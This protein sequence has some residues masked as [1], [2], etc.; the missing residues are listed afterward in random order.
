MIEQSIAA[1][2]PDLIQIDP[3]EGP[4]RRPLAS[5]VDF[6]CLI[7]AEAASQ[8]AGI[9]ALD[10]VQERLVACHLNPALLARSDACRLL[11]AAEQNALGFGI[12]Q[13]R[14]SVQPQAQGFMASRGYAADGSDS[15]GPGPV[16][17]VKSLEA[18]APDWVKRVFA[19]HRQ[20]GIPDNYGARRRLRMVD[21]CKQLDSIGLDVFHRQ[22]FLHPDAA[23]AWRNMRETA[24]QAGVDLQLV[25]AFRAR[26]YQAGLIQAKLERG[27]SME[28][29]LSA[30]AAPGFSEH[31]SGRAVD[32]KAPGSAPLEEDF[33]KTSAYRWLKANAGFFGFFETLGAANVHG[34]IWEP[35][36]WCYRSGLGQ[37]GSP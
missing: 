11:D 3:A 7:I 23:Q 26:E 21:D 18:G 19:L 5:L 9:V 24:A 15:L 29:I 12:R 13:L 4:V 35:W 1:R 8:P 17:L 32:I 28:R 31:H 16:K 37:S 10:L 22:Q 27:L 6:G 30:S 33:A 36:H 25:S 20:L 34:I 2:L 14:V